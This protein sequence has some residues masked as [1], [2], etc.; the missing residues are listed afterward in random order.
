[1]LQREE[2]NN[3]SYHGPPCTVEN[4]LPFDCF[5]SGIQA[6]E[7]NVL[8]NNTT[9]NLQ[10]TSKQL[11]K[12][13]P[14]RIAPSRHFIILASGLHKTVFLFWRASVTKTREHPIIFLLMTPT[15]DTDPKMWVT[16]TRMV[17]WCNPT[18]LYKWCL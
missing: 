10:L 7:P 2:R 9:Y 11:S 4:Q 1:M 16:T 18:K 13:S 12:L 14:H 15:K 5:W 8:V 6:V 3:V 17:Q